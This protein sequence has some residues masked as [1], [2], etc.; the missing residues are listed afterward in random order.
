LLPKVDW[1]SI[2]SPD[3]AGSPPKNGG[4]HQ[5]DRDSS[6]Y[7]HAYAEAN[8]RQTLGAPAKAKVQAVLLT[9]LDAL[10]TLHD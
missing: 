8:F 5:H 2:A 9:R 7:D 4:N 10:S 6:E 3:R 1:Q